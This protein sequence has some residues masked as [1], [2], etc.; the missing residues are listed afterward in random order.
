VGLNVG[1]L[2]LPSFTGFRAPRLD[3]PRSSVLRGGG[4]TGPAG[5]R[6][7]SGR[8]QTGSRSGL[9]VALHHWLGSTVIVRPARW[10]SD[11]LP[12]VS[13]DRLSFFFI[14]SRS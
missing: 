6:T 10:W 14:V 12:L 8:S 13:G 7:I 4:L 2:F 11:R 5:R 3:H 1:F 9:T